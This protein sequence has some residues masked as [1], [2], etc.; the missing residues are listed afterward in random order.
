ME[1]C[2]E[3]D[4]VC[5]HVHITRILNEK[6]DEIHRD[7]YRDAPMILNRLDKNFEL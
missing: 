3:A 2:P 5:D 1:H 4:I 6:L 7:L